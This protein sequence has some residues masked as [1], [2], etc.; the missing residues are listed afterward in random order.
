MKNF[1]T[2]ITTGL[3]L[4]AC[5]QSEVSN[6]KTDTDLK[7]VQAV[8]TT[9]IKFE[10]SLSD[11]R[12]TVGVP[13]KI[14]VDFSGKADSLMKTEFST[15][16]SLSMMSDTSASIQMNKT[17]KA[18]TQTIT[19]VPQTEGIHYVNI[20]EPGSK[21]KPSVI[22]IIAGDKDIKE[23]LQ[24]PGEIVEQEDGTKVITMKADEG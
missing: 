2:I 10:H 21:Q 11:E 9:A 8:S 4:A 7:P 23:Y 1:L 24:T 6:A 12:A 18:E 19:V 17:G 13:Y 14:M 3:I 15:S 22:R 16:S 20:F 5:Q